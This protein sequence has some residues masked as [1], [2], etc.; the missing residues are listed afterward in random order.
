MGFARAAFIVG[1]MPTSDAD[2]GP[3]VAITLS[4]HLHWRHMDRGAPRKGH[5]YSGKD[6]PC[7]EQGTG[8]IH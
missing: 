2:A 6:P 1:S 3:K 8:L 5:K 7:A 4:G